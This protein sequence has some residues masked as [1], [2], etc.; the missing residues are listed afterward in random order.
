MLVPANISGMIKFF[1]YI[2]TLKEDYDLKIVYYYRFLTLLG[3]SV[4]QNPQINQ[5][6]SKW[7]PLSE[8]YQYN[9]E[10]VERITLRQQTL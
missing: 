7:N 6:I 1:D 2:F 4:I 5:K 10:V 3:S 8:L 9:S